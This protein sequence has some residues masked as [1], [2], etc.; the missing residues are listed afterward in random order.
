MQQYTVVVEYRRNVANIWAVDR[1]LMGSPK[2]CHE[3]DDELTDAKFASSHDD[4]ESV[5]GTIGATRAWGFVQ[6]GFDEV[7]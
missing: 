5:V 1:V 7:R 4:D 3:E 6:V 2:T